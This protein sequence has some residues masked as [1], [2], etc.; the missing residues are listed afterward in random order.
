MAEGPMHGTF[1]WNELLTTDMERCKAFYAEVVGWSSKEMPMPGDDSGAAYT[2]W[3]V[4][5]KEVGGGFR[6]AGPQFEG[7]PPHWMSYV[8]VD[9]VD[10]ACTRATEAG[11]AVRVPP[12]DIPGVGRFCWIADP[13]GA[14]LALM[15]P[16]ARD[17]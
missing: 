15:T 5:D 9:D 11:G 2:L 13:T 12:M 14:V 7:V 1:M 10:A 8:C 4:G 17:S 6:M 16:A 3:T